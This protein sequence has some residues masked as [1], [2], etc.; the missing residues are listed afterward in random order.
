MDLYNREIVAHRMA[1][2]PVFELVSG[3]LGA[4]LLWA[5]QTGGHTVHLNQGWHYKI[6]PYQAMLAL[7]GVTQSISRMG[8]CLD[9]AVTESFFGTL[10]AEYFHLATLGRIDEFEA[11]VHNYI[12]YFN[13]ER[14]KLGLKAVSPM[15]NRL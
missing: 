12:Y 7:G 3:K 6:R 13:H 4:A 11:D 15:E 2:R 8:N 1:S 14:I 5:G 9:K 10:K